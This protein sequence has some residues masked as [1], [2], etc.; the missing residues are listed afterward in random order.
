MGELLRQYCE[1]RNVLKC[2]QNAPCASSSHRVAIA[3]MYGYLV[4][5]LATACHE[6]L[7]CVKIPDFRVIWSPD[8]SSL[9]TDIRRALQNWRNNGCSTSGV[10]LDNIQSTK[11]FYKNALKEHKRSCNHA[12][13][14]SMRNCIDSANV[15]SFWKL[16]NKHKRNAEQSR[17]V[18]LPSDFVKGFKGN[19]INSSNN[20]AMVN[21]FINQF[22]CNSVANC[23]D[24]LSLSVEDI[25]KAC[26]SLSI[27]NCL[28][29]NDITISHFHYA[30]PS[31]FI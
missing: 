6:A 12:R 22:S 28:D 14:K 27:S 7:K 25:E 11:R 31:V 13:L 24:I 26:D 8:L 20:G 9:K 2:C 23:P 15:T 3:D 5:S 19:F 10:L 16:L 30:H 21:N 18:L 29:Y 17:S 1:S 4:H